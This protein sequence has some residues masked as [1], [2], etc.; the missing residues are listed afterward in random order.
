MWKLTI[1]QD[2]FSQCS[3]IH[4]SLLLT[5]LSPMLLRRLTH[6]HRTLCSNPRSWFFYIRFATHCWQLHYVDS[7]VSPPGM[8]VGDVRMRTL[9]KRSRSLRARA[10]VR[11]VVWALYVCEWG[12]QATTN[13]KNGDVESS[14]PTLLAGF[15]PSGQLQRWRNGQLLLYRGMP[16]ARTTLNARR[17]L[18]QLAVRMR[19][20]T[21]HRQWL[22]MWRRWRLWLW[23]RRK[24]LHNIR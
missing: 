4:P 19:Q 1:H 12:M 14:L 10:C 3:S 11:M 24:W 20:R 13:V 2:I 23:G 6:H 17:L 18:L 15:C 16:F 8:H 9:F 5:H 21:L 7:I 22:Y